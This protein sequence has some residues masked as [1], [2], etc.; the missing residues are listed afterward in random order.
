MSPMWLYAPIHQYMPYVHRLPSTS[1]CSS[2]HPY[3][4]HILLCSPYV[5]GSWGHQYICQGFLSLLVYP[6]AA[7]FIMVIPV[8]PHHCW[9][10][11]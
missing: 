4:L 1:I 5:M 6:F 3:V 10:L 9:L 8:A 2:V 11:P 7:Q